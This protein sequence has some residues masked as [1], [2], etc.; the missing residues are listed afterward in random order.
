MSKLLTGVFLLGGAYALTRP[1]NS[2]NN[3]DV[4][5]TPRYTNTTPPVLTTG[6]ESI[7]GVKVSPN[8]RPDYDNWSR[9]HWAAWYGAIYNSQGAVAARSKVWDAWNSKENPQSIQVRLQTPE[10]LEFALVVYRGK[11]TIGAPHHIDENSTPIYD[12]W[13]AWWNS[14]TPWGCGDWVTYF[15]KM[16]SAWGKIFAQQKWVSAWQH[17]DNSALGG[18]AASWCTGDCDFIAKMDAR[19]IDAAAFGTRSFCGLSN[20]AGNL[21][22][23]V[24]HT[25]EG[26]ANTAKVASWLLP[27]ALGGFVFY[28]VTQ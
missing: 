21:I 28:Q 10:A 12:T 6:G 18:L 20:T 27:V 5:I 16:E 22:R 3:K 4:N 26:I 24:E 11:S 19:G 23:A 25:S 13:S 9:A 7:A 1:K 8:E 17:P 14:T 2:P 15:D